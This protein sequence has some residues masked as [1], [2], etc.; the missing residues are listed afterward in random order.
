MPGVTRWNESGITALSSFV[1][2]AEQTTP[3]RPA[4]LHSIA[5]RSTW[6]LI[7]LKPTFCNANRMVSSAAFKSS[8]DFPNRSIPSSI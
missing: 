8:S 5:N 4:S 6:R 3:S 2:A 7:R 1:S